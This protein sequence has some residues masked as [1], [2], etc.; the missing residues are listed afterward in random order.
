[1]APF[2]FEYIR[3][4]WNWRQ[5][6]KLDQERLYLRIKMSQLDHLTMETANNRTFLEKTDSYVET[7]GVLYY[8]AVPQVSPPLRGHSV[9]CSNPSF[10]VILW[11]RSKL[12]SDLQPTVPTTKM[13]PGLGYGMA[14]G[15]PGYF[16]REPTG[17]PYSRIPNQYH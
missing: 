8:L 12:C 5:I 11:F 1:M 10:Y 16:G 3:L 7:E 9:V 6:G 14:F 13:C 15:I 2:C 17:P 4:K